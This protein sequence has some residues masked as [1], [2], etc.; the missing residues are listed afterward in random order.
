MTGTIN[1]LADL[2]I[3]TSGNDNSLTLSDSTQLDAALSSNLDSVK[4]L[5]TDPTNGIMV[6]LSGYLDRTIG[7]NGNLIAKQNSLTKQASDIDTQVANL[8]KQ[9]S[10][11]SD[12]WTSE[13]VSMETTQQQLNQQLSYLTKQFGSSSG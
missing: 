5:F 12:H 9:I 7:E 2:G 1:H 4:Q 3:Q 11:D 10:S 6:G 13:F 8:E